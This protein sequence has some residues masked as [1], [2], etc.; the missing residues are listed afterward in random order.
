MVSAQNCS[1]FLSLTA[2]AL[3]ARI[4]DQRHCDEFRFQTACMRELRFQTAFAV[5]CCCGA[6]YDVAA[7]LIFERTIRDSRR[8]LMNRVVYAFPTA[9]G[10]IVLNIRRRAFRDAPPSTQSGLIG[11]MVTFTEFDEHYI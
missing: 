11:T 1:G 9:K 4:L 2:P 6:C 5:A 8:D 7:S 3:N 10:Y